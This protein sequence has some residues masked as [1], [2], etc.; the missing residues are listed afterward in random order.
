MNQNLTLEAGAAAFG[1]AQHPSTILALQLLELV[2]QHG[3]PY[4]MLDMGCGSGILSLRAAQLWPIPIIAADIEQSAVEA[5]QA[6]AEANGASAITAFR[7]DGYNHPR[8]QQEGC[9]ALITANIL[10]E[11]LIPTAQDAVSLMA[12]EGLLLLSG[13]L[14]WREAEVCAPYEALGLT[15][16]NRAK[17]GEWVALLFQK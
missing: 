13:I 5:T 4:N 1:D 2:A 11:I 7:S 12:E 8:I 14:E 6:N 3:C 17:K 16:V 9:F 10:P 15:L